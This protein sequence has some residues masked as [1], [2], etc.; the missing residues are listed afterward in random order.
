MFEY[1]I[2]LPHHQEELFA[3]EQRG[4][5]SFED[6]LASWSAPWR[7]ESLEHYLKLGWSFGAWSD[8]VLKGY[9]LAQ[10]IVFFAGHTQSLWME[11]LNFGGQNHLALGLVDVAYRWS[12]D[13]HLQRLILPFAP[14]VLKDD[15]RVQKSPLGW[16]E[17][18][19]SKS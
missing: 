4:L 5:K 14:E 6:E 1:R 16:Y 8:K 19:T 9:F 11:H 15:P 18:R 3:L 10:P 17:M 12:R 13:K 7:K 2:L